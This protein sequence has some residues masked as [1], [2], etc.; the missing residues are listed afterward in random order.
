MPIA[1]QI[2][3]KLSYIQAQYRK[4]EGILEAQKKNYERGAYLKVTKPNC[5]KKQNKTN[6]NTN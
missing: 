1:K 3:L 5:K 4:N 2:K 6:Q